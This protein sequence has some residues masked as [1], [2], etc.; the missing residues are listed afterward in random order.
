MGEDGHCPCES[1][2]FPLLQKNGMRIIQRQRG[3]NKMSV[4][5]LMNLSCR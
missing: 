3:A 1:W 2:P 4:L 5:S